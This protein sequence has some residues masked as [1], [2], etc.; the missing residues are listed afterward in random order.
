MNIQ[1]A[2]R[3]VA[4][5]KE[6]GLSQEELAE[7]I[8]VSRQAISKWENGE[9]AP[10]T[11]NLISLADVY[12]ISLD[13]L[14]GK[15]KA[16]KPEEVEAEVVE[17][18]IK[19]EDDDDDDDDDDDE[20]KGPTPIRFV[21]RMIESVGFLLAVVGY[22]LLGFLLKGPTGN[23]GWASCWTIFFVPMLLVGLLYAIERRRPSRF[24]IALLVVG[25]FCTMGIVGNA[26]GLNLWHPYWVMFFLIPIYHAFCGAI[27]SRR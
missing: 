2:N 18:P 15:E 11:D 24:P 10:D 8:G 26:Y 19:A 6:K 9:S 22:L 1:F 14:L 7:K 17:N 25:V 16:E 13:E 12:G 4:L 5:R 27:E 3:L 20:R 21:R 23:L